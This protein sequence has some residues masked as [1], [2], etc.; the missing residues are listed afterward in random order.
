MVEEQRYLLPYIAV[1]CGPSYAL[2]TS[3]GIF[4]VPCG[5]NRVRVLVVGGGGGGGSGAAGGGAAGSVKIGVFDVQPNEAL[6]VTVGKGGKGSTLKL[7]SCVQDSIAGERSS[8]ARLLRA[9]GGGNHSGS[10]FAS[11]QGASGGSGGGE[12]CTNETGRCRSGAGGSGGFNG[13]K[14]SGGRTYGV[15]SGQG[16]YAEQFKQFR[17]NLITSGAGGRGSVHDAPGGGGAG[18]VLINDNSPIAG[19]GAKPSGAEGGRGYGSGGGSGFLELEDDKAAP[20]H[21]EGGKGAD[22]VVYVE[23]WWE[24]PTRKSPSITLQSTI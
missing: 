8:F 14:S 20:I 5:V 23:W 24:N 22:G 1:A 16:A 21:N 2:F 19:S 9:D 4:T 15:G 18:G 7:G 13:N 10:C 3:S 17:F 12:G 6:K 11:W